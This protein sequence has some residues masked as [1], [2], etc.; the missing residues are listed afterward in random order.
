MT[1]DKT[2]LAAALALTL[3]LT[4]CS[5]NAPTPDADTKEGAVE[6]A[7]APKGF[8][9]S[10]SVRTL[11]GAS[12]DG[13]SKVIV[14]WFVDGEDGDSVYKLGEGSLGEDTFSVTLSA[15]TPPPEALTVVDSFKLGIGLLLVVP[16]DVDLPD[17]VVTEEVMGEVLG[18]GIKA[19]APRHAIV[20]REG[21]TKDVEKLRG[22]FTWPNAFPEGEL[23]CG[24]GAENEDPE[25]PF[26]IFVPSACDGFEIVIGSGEW[27]NFT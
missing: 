22:R 25:S 5:T 10:G 23:S 7:T 6:E 27:I 1:I 13:P 2:T 21:S 24:E 9:V 3:T 19:N 20:F 18:G 12:L 14:I 11:D 15:P 26:E 16:A 4:A 17:G 8:T